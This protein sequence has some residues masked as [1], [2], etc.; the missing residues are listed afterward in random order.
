MFAEAHDRLR[1]RLM[2]SR[3]VWNLRCTH[4][5][6]YVRRKFRSLQFDRFDF[7]YAIENDRNLVTF[8]E[9][10]RFN[11]NLWQDYEV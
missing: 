1:M 5:P 9:T 7:H 8:F 11:P 2:T 10:L 6:L 4:T 3:M